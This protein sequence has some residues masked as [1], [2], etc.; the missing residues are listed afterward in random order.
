MTIKILILLFLLFLD[1]F[2]QEMDSPLLTLKGHKDWV[3]SIDFSPVKIDRILVIQTL[4][5]HCKTAL[6]G[7]LIAEKMSEEE[8]PECYKEF[9]LA[10]RDMVT[11]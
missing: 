6:A 5:Q 9:L 1:F 11:D 7:S 4:K 3:G 10:S 8:I 2:A